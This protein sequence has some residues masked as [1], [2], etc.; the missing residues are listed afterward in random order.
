MRRILLLVLAIACRRSEPQPRP[1]PTPTPVTSVADAGAAKSADISYRTDASN[2][3]VDPKLAATGKTSMVAS[4]DHHATEAGEA[5]LA[6]GGNAVDAAV[7]TAFV[8]AVTHPSAGNLAGGGFAVVRAGKGQASALD[9]RE[10]APAAATPNMY[11]DASGNPTKESLIGDRA[12]GV[13]GSVSGLYELHR[14]YGKKKWADVL[15]PAIK[16]A[17]DG[18]VV[19]QQLHDSL[20]RVLGYRKSITTAPLWWPASKPLE[21]GATVKES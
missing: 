21:V 14:K 2:F 12:C 7:T 9:F 1:A 10:T 4:E 8:L 20:V 19:E 15:A 16:L 18:F 6:A 11:L 5:M 3:H 13:P 17:T